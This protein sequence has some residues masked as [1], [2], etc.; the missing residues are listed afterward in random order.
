MDKKYSNTEIDF[1]FL[2]KKLWS[3]KFTIIL[4]TFFFATIGLIGSIFLLEPAYTSTTKIYVVNKRNTGESITTQDLQAGDYLVKDYKEIIT[5]K[6]VL[7]TVI[8]N[9][10]LDMTV[11]ELYEKVAVS[12]PTNTRIISISVEDENPSTATH[13]ANAV[14]EVA[15]EK[16]KAVT[17]VDDVTTMEVAEDSLQPSSPNIKRNAVLGGLLGG[18]IAVM[19]ILLSEVLDDRV[20]RP[21]DVE[22]V[23]GMTLLGIVPETS[24]MK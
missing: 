4:M 6:D 15:S 1:F 20:K 17:K 14:R 8:V 5:S 22:E 23:L 3:R 19:S 13:L 12:I 24:Q 2:L 9:N 7:S 10:N 11:A 21:E 18:F 16:I